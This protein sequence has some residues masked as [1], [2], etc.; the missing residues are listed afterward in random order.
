MPEISTLIEKL[1]NKVRTTPAPEKV[2]ARTARPRPPV[3]PTCHNTGW[4]RKDVPIDH[5]DFG[6]LTP[7]HC[8]DM[9]VYGAHSGLT[10]KEIQFLSWDEVLDQGEAHKAMQVVQDVVEAGY[11]MVYLWGGPGIA[12]SL[13]LKIAVAQ[14]INRRKQA[15]YISMSALLDNLREAYD[16]DYPNM[17]S[18]ER[19]RRWSSI[20]VLAIDE[21]DKV[22][23]T[24]YVHERRM[25]LLD[26]RYTSAIREQSITLYASNE[27]PEAYDNYITDRLRDGRCQVVKLTGESLRPTMTPDFKF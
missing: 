7:C 21:F 27:A 12:K 6:T 26:E 15:A 14:M 1:E 3:C 13:L 5:P 11:G 19:L 25:R 24:E 2:A 20:P 17:Q 8:Q 18:V 9:D 22:K 4:L 16:T 23:D 10:E